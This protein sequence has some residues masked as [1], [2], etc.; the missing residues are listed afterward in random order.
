MA[1]QPSTNFQGDGQQVNES[2]DLEAALRNSR[3][4]DGGPEPDSDNPQGGAQGAGTFGGIYK[5]SAPADKVLGGAASAPPGPLFPVPDLPPQSFLTSSMLRDMSDKKVRVLL[6]DDKI[7]IG[8]LRTYDQF[9]N[10][11]ITECTERI[12]A[13]NPDW[14]PV[15]GYH[16]KLPKWFYCD[17]AV[18]GAITFRGENV[19]ICST[20][21]LDKEDDPSP[22]AVLGDEQVIRALHAEQ[23]QARKDLEARIAAKL[24]KAGIEPGFGM[25]V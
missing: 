19:A 20:I 3:Q 22:I 23:V 9:A 11:T 15:D 4:Q 16:G 1:A 5:S 21:D 12:S 24:K 2:I 8:I 25:Q 6:R 7:F 13:L 18:T 14:D 10:L 17:V